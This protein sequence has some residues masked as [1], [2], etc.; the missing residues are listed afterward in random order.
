MANL[1]VGQKLNYTYT[2]A[3]QSVTLPPG[4]YK[5]EVWGAQGGYR[6]DS[7]KGGKGGYSAGT[8]KITVETTFYIY[9]GGAGGSSTS[10]TSTVITGGFNGGGYRYGYKGGGGGTD[11]RVAVDSLYARVIVAGGG[12]SCGNSSKTGMYG[13]GTNGG[14][15][16]E[17]YGSHGEGGSQ[18]GNTAN[19]TVATSQYK[20]N[21]TSN[22]PGGFGF[23]GFGVYASSGYGGAGGGGWY[24]GCGAVPDGSGDDDRGGGGGSGY[25]YTS[26]SASNYPSGCKLNSSHYLTST[27][28]KGGNESFTD[29]SG[30]NVTGHTGDGAARITVVEIAAIKPPTNLTTKVENQ[31]AILSWTAST[32]E[33][34][35]GYKVY[36]DGTLLGTTTST[37]YD[38]YLSPNKSHT[39]EVYTYNGYGQSVESS[40]L[41]LSYSLP[42]PP[43]R[44]DLHVQNGELL[45]SW[46]ESVSEG[47]V[48]YRVY[49][50]DN[51]L[52][53]TTP[54]VP[55][56]T[57]P[58]TN[59]SLVEK[60][61]IMGEKSTI[62]SF[63]YPIEAS[64]EYVF[65]VSSIN[66][67]GEGE[68][69]SVRL[70]VD[71][72]IKFDSISITPNPT[73]TNSPVTISAAVT[74]NLNL[75]IL[76]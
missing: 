75:T 4:T 47:V 7:S 13:G 6:T 54:W 69:V 51:V 44:I 8:I 34:I 43:V 35:S 26:S 40:T 62:M 76:N 31:N 71:S 25:V 41:S 74:E 65:G 67:Y 27:M 55:K 53:G 66:N 29:Y 18:T 64:K 10:A 50:G 19:T 24:G 63:T 58:L 5:L 72:V 16:T 22:W 42:D 37:T 45:L 23:G 12:G 1:S 49:L 11:I 38:C 3:K 33:N 70:R 61:L 21:S 15:A 57:F 48:G 2:G 36:R 20:T 56:F 59:N 39:I 17:S 60:K 73:N 28:L 14:A 9:V 32:S 52:L 30:S 68:K 46:P